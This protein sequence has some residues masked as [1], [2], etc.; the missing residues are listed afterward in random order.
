[1]IALVLSTVVG[2][3]SGKQI[4]GRGSSAPKTAEGSVVPPVTIGK[5]PPSVTPPL[6]AVALQDADLP[7]E[8]VERLAACGG[9]QIFEIKKEVADVRPSVILNTFARRFDDGRVHN[10]RVVGAATA[11]DACVLFLDSAVEAPGW[12]LKIVFTPDRGETWYLSSEV[13]KPYYLAS[14]EAASFDT[15][16]SGCMT[17]KLDAGYGTDVASGRYQAC[18]TD[19]GGT[20]T[21]F[22]LI[23]EP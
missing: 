15:A 2:C 13:K 10:S 12:E 17:L 14:F 19:S 11:G 5:L 18:T 16:T 4:N 7:T 9:I 20:W 8:G 6:D 23:V 21:P 1:M 22:E 3:A